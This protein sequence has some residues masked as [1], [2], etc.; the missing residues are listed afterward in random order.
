MRKNI[1][2]ILAVVLFAIVVTA[3]DVYLT[4]GQ[5]YRRVRAKYTGDGMVEI[6]LPSGVIR[7]RE[8]DVAYIEKEE[9]PDSE[10]QPTA[11]EPE[12]SPV[13]KAI[14]EKMQGT[15]G[16]K[17]QESD[18]D[19]DM[20]KAKGLLTLLK[21]KDEA[22]RQ[23]G[24]AALKEMGKKAV[25]ALVEA[26][27]DPDNTFRYQVAKFI[28]EIQPKEATKQILEALYAISPDT[29][30]VPRFLKLYAL[31]LRDTLRSMTGQFFNYQ[32]EL[33]TQ[34]EAI[35]KWVDWY[36]E[37]WKNLPPQIGDPVKEDGQ[38]E[39]EYQKKLEEARK[40]KLTKVN[41]IPDSLQEEGP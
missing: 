12:L 7:L 5:V 21:D 37:N 40:L 22:I 6:K 29:G 35:R 20:K 3:D 1:A 28:N 32:P 14:L 8:S 34:K 4:N 41:F 39:E 17:T 16:P 36:N 33:G 23:Q 13:Q 19:A 31:S 2:L 38:A 18:A 26:L 9:V 15:Q 24:I 25:P 30:I 11:R 27:K 10:F